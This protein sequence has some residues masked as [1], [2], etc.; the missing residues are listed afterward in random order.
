MCDKQ[1]LINTFN[2]PEE[3]LDILKS[4]SFYDVETAARI[5]QYKEIKRNLLQ[6]FD[7][8]LDFQ[9]ADEDG[10]WAVKFWREDADDEDAD[11]EDADPDQHLMIAACVCYKCGE[12]ENCHGLQEIPEIIMC[13]CAH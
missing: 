1:L 13:S 11:D 8:T 2:L 9:P 10:C 5:K 4:F 7:Q 12:Y 6:E 3:L